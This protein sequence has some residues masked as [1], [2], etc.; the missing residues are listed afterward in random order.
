M[1]RVHATAA[2]GMQAAWTGM[3]AA[4]QR[5][6]VASVAAIAPR[7]ER[8]DEPPPRLEKGVV[9]LLA[10]RQAFLA[11]LAVFRRADEAQQQVLD[12]RA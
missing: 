9:D 5:I 3:Q 11:N 2:S 6:A 12:L 1:S 10:Q 8:L 4:S 7:P